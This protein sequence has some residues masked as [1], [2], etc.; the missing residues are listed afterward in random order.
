MLH[1]KNSGLRLSFTLTDRFCHRIIFVTVTVFVIVP[2]LT[3]I[4]VFEHFVVSQ[5]EISAL[6]R[7]SAFP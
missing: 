1:Y 2:F 6:P 3:K 7:I 4:E 5:K